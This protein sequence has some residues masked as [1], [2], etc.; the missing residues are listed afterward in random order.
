MTN[1][2]ANPLINGCG[3]PL[4][5]VGEGEGEGGRMG[6]F[7]LGNEITLGL[8]KKGPIHHRVEPSQTGS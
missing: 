6:G 5:G 2:G 8:P 4:G 1:E 7:V 3:G